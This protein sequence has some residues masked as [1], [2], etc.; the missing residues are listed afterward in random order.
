M[1]TTY[2]HCPESGNLYAVT[3]ESAGIFRLFRDDR[4]T[5]PWTFLEPNTDAW[6]AAHQKIFRNGTVTEV[7][8]EDMV[9]ALPEAPAG[10]FPSWAERRG[11]GKALAAADFPA[12]AGWLAGESGQAARVFVELY[13]DSYE[14]MF[15]DGVFRYLRDVYRTQELPQEEPGGPSTWLYTYPVFTLM[16]DG[17]RLFSP[18]FAPDDFEHYAFQE[19]LGRKGDGGINV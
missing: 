4:S 10:P 13:E 19:V 1:K 17:E 5:G 9:P 14:S 12:V 6:D 18:D 15:G 16:S 8:P 2:F 3:A 11:Q 7:T